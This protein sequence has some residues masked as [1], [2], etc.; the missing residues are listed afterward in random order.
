MH[1]GRISSLPQ[2]SCLY[3]FQACKN[4]SRTSFNRLCRSFF[5][6][7]VSMTGACCILGIFWDLCRGRRRSLGTGYNSG[8]SGFAMKLRSDKEPRF[9]IVYQPRATRKR[10][11]RRP[12]CRR[13]LRGMREVRGAC[14]IVSC[15]HL[16]K[17]RLE[18]TM[19]ATLFKNYP[20]PSL[21]YAL[22][23]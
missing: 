17:I 14:S 3:P 23:V 5:S 2:A 19:M 10:A 21:I 6:A 9:A 15:H 13:F 18:P 12:A 7:R 4:V 20:K 16:G 11:K 1:T 8:R 22:A